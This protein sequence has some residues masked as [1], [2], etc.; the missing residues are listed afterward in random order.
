MSFKVGDTVHIL[1][2]EQMKKAA[3]GVNSMGDLRMDGDSF[4]SGM[5]KYCGKSTTIRDC[6]DGNRK[7]ILNIDNGGWAWTYDMLEEF[8]P[9]ARRIQ[10]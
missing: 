7:F 8:D 1:S 9:L 6:S 3:R 4:V 10:T 2:Y 5:M